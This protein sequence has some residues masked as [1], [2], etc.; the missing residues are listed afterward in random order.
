MHNS[1]LSRKAHEYYET[2]A[3][4]CDDHAHDTG[5]MIF[6]P[7]FLAKTRSLTYF[8]LKHIADE[9]VH[10]WICIYMKHVADEYDLKCWKLSF[11]K[12]IWQTLNRLHKEQLNCERN[13]DIEEVYDLG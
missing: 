7:N 10:D 9:I 11:K 12:I 4:D 2:L 8:T 5:S 13:T 1:C 3:W 6:N